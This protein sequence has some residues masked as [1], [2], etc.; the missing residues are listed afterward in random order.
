[1]RF[2]PPPN[3]PAP[4]HGWTP[5][6]GWKPDPT[7][8][9]EPAGWIFWLPDGPQP[10]N[11]RNQPSAQ[12]PAPDAAAQPP[13]SAM[14]G[15]ASPSA[16][17]PP[18]APLATHATGPAHAA[19]TT[20]K[21]IGLFG[22]RKTAEHLTAEV[23]RLTNHTVELHAQ[24]AL[25]NQ[26]LAELGLLGDIELER[27]RDQLRRELADLDAA[28]E[29]KKAEAV[30]ALAEFEAEQTRRRGAAGSERAALER[31]LTAIR[32]MIAQTED[33]AILQ[34]IG[35]YQYRHPLTD[36]AAYQ[37]ELARLTDQIRTTAR[38]DGGAITATTQWS[39]NDSQA[40][41]RA[42]VRDFSKLMLRAYNAEA[43]N[44]VRGLKP[45]KLTTAIDRLGK[46]VT[47]IERLGKTMS[48]SVTPAYHQLRIK[49]LEL[50]ADYL[51]KLAEDKERAR[52]EAARLRDERK[53]QAEIERERAKLEKEREHYLNALTQLQHS[54][55]I[56]AIGRLQDQ[57]AEIE[58]GIADVDYRAAN[59]RAGYVYVISNLGSFG[60]SIVKIGMTRRLEPRDRI[61][62]LSDAS[63]PFNFDTHALFF[64]NDAVGI[65]ASMHRTFADRAVNR[66]NQRREFFH[67]SPAEARD[68]LLKLTG[69]LLEFTETP[70]AIE[71]RRSLT[72]QRTTEPT[73]GS[74]DLV[75]ATRL[76]PASPSAH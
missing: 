67:V 42:M 34:E 18:T 48:I 56:E 20:D 1:M 15:N 47:T 63:V 72:Y 53:A 73:P 40:K 16:A 5:P 61:R 51:E 19:P 26:R 21:K 9:P 14:F 54:G 50:T 38:R 44:L 29:R 66:V 8:G 32:N 6:E 27:R 7:W 24:L 36:A 76:H 37:A 25:Q 2:N 3:W 60:E 17:T 62:E 70:E 11:A 55:D 23:E 4:P 71:Y 65:E 35:I 12:A 33:I 28:V 64:S 69:D 41:G 13:T 22:V 46:T 39:V 31:Q 10:S 75:D 74:S 68:A 30:Q 52:E 43:D 57:L 49:E 58:R 59:I 45:Y